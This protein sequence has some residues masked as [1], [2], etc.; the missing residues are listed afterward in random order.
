EVREYPAEVRPGHLNDLLTLPFEF[1]L[2]QSFTAMTK[3]DGRAA[4]ARQRRWLTD[5][6]DDSKTQIAELDLALDDL[7]A[8]KFIMGE[9]HATM[10]IFGKS[11]DDTLRHAADAISTLGDNEIIGHL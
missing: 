2:T 4:L 11:A 6:A 7:A 8:G 10:M 9:H 1:V 5:S 3:A